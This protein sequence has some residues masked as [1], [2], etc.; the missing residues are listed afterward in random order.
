ML[1][2]TATTKYPILD[3]IKERW[4]PRSFSNEAVSQE[5]LMT[6]LEAA[7][8]SYSSYNEQPWR[9]IVALKETEKFQKVL[10]TLVPPNAAWAKN[11]AAFIVSFAKMAMSKEGEPPNAAA[12]HDAGAANM[13]MTLQAQSMGIYVHPMGGFN[14][15][16]MT[17]IFETPDDVLPLCVFAVG[18]L[19]KPENLPEPF[20]K[21]EL[22][23]RE[24]KPLEEIIL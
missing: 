19:G 1:N 11:A 14:P 7:S 4:S 17:M 22:K 8:W 3:Q 10:S 9:Y 12:V 5:E 18:H 20:D 6:M 16:Q 21:I 15:V 2:K 23:P 24:R 13:L